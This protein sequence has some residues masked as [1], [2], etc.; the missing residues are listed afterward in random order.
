[1]KQ[2]NKT[3]TNYGVQFHSKNGMCTKKTIKKLR[4]LKNIQ[5]YIIQITKTLSIVFSRTV[6][7]MHNYV[8]FSFNMF[9]AGIQIISYFE[10]MHWAA[11]FT[12]L[13]N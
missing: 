7:E 13:C 2:K 10:I 11:I 9:A 1:M 3:K 8:S 5:N 12:L 4:Y 6:A